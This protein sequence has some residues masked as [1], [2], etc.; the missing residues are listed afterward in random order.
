MAAS[1]LKSKTEVNMDK[2]L[3]RILVFTSKYETRSLA[4]VENTRGIG[5][6]KQVDTVMVDTVMDIIHQV[7]VAQK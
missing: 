6:A 7:F 4:R 1:P 5:T 3:G 2:K